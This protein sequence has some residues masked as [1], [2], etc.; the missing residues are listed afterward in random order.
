MKNKNYFEGIKELAIFVIAFF[1]F[2]LVMTLAMKGQD[3]WQLANDDY[4]ICVHSEESKVGSVEVFKFQLVKQFTY[5]LKFKG[6]QDIKVTVNNTVLYLNEMREI[7]LQ[8]QDFVSIWVQN[9]SSKRI[10][11]SV[12]VIQKT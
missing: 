12:V 6:S 7:E 8:G 2:M 11:F 4:G 5:K 10:K 1:T 3:S 9:R